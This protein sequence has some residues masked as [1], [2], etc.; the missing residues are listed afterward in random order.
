MTLYCISCS[1]EMCS[2]I[3]ACQHMVDYGCIVE[4]LPKD[5]VA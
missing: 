5:K 2:V 3:E 4:S 1:M